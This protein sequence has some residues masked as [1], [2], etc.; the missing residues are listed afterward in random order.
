MI[1]PATPDYR[2]GYIQGMKDG[3]AAFAHM[4]AGVYYVGTTGL[5]LKEGI[6]LVDKGE[7]WNQE[8]KPTEGN[9]HETS[10]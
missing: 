10:K 3:I 7:I 6:A 5:T 2:N 9:R 1:I 8:V 4:N